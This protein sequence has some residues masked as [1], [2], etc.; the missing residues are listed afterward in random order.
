MGLWRPIA[1]V[2]ASCTS[3]QFGTV[4][5]LPET[6]FTALL[7]EQHRLEDRILT[8]VADRMC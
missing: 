4:F 8:T 6:A 2:L 3:V 7:H 1:L 5:M